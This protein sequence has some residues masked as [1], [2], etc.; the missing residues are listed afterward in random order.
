MKFIF[1][2]NKKKTIQLTHKSAVKW[3]NADNITSVILYSMVLI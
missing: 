1:S 3:Y 2:I